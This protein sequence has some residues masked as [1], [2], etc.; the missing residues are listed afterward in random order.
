MQYLIAVATSDGATSEVPL[1]SAGL[2][3]SE[4]SAASR[5]HS[6]RSADCALTGDGWDKDAAAAI[7]ITARAMRP[8]AA[9]ERAWD[10]FLMPRIFSSRASG[11]PCT[12]PKQR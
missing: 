6:T 4:G 3:G 7:T 10:R 12:H 5:S 11:G 1:T 2:S 9:G 8:V